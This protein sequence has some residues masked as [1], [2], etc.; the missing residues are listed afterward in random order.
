MLRKSNGLT[1]KEMARRCGCSFQYIHRLETDKAFRPKM[2]LLT[3][4][5]DCLSFDSDTL[6]N[7]AGKIPEDVYR[8][9]VNNPELNKVIRDFKE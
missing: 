3:K 4:M 7:E 1:L 2:W 6:I 5:A 9:V 8:K